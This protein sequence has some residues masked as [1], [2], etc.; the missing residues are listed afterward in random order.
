MHACMHAYIHTYTHI[1]TYIHAYIHTFMHT[2]MH[3]YI[4]TCTH[5]FMHTHILTYIH[6]CT[7]THTHIYIYSYTYLQIYTCVCIPPTDLSMSLPVGDWYPDRLNSR[8][9]GNAQRRLK[10]LEYWLLLCHVMS[11][12]YIQQF[13]S[14]SITKYPTRIYI[15]IHI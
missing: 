14:T 7:H 11:G 13:R 9:G 5:T 10:H 15:Y 12:G 2:Y 3:T 8:P 6:T 4:H 1:H